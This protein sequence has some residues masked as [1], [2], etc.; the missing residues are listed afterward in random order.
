MR[1]RDLSSLSR[2]QLMAVMR[3]GHPIAPLD[4]DDT[5]YHGVSL[6]LPRALERV[7][8]KTFIKAFYR[9]PGSGQLWGWNVRVRQDEP[10]KYRPMMRRGQPLT[11]G[12]FRVL[13]ARGQVMPRPYEHG[14]LL[15]YGAGRRG[16][17]DPLGAL[18]DP[19]VAVRAGSSDL[20]L[21]WSYLQLGRLQVP[22]PSF[23]SLVR[24][25]PLTHVAPAP[26]HPGSSD[27]MNSQGSSSSDR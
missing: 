25:G 5:E 4:L 15:D 9:R 11:F 1:A 2:E 27:H 19:I 17:L 23:F 24:A 8:W 14:L 22:T 13:E 12:H 3:A 7:T 10:D 16:R 18:R 21:G 6:G 20:L 26:S